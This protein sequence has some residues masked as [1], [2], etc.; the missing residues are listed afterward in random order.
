MPHLALSDAQ[1]PATVGEDHG[2]AP[3]TDGLGTA[4]VY[5]SLH[6]ATQP[7]ESKR[8]PLLPAI[9]DGGKIAAPVAGVFGFVGDVLSPLGPWVGVLLSLSIIG[10]CGLG[11]AVSQKIK[12]EKFLA[13]RLIPERLFV[14][15]LFLCLASGLWYCLT[16]L[17][18]DSDRGVVATI[19]PGIAAIQDSLLGLKDDVADVKADTTAILQDTGDI[20][21]ELGNIGRGGIIKNPTTP[22]EFYHNARFHELEGKFRDSFAAYA[23]YIDSNQEFVDPYITYLRLYQPQKG[24][25]AT[26]AEIARLRNR[27][28]QNRALHLVSLLLISGEEKRTELEQ[29]ARDNPEFGPAYLFAADSFV[30]SEL[31]SQSAVAAALENDYLRSF[32]AAADR[33][34]VQQ[35]YLDKLLAVAKVDEARARVNLNENDDKTFSLFAASPGTEQF[36]IND[37]N[38]KTVFYKFEDEDWTTLTDKAIQHLKSPIA[39]ITV[40][41]LPIDKLKQ[42]RADRLA[43]DPEAK[44]SLSLRYLDTSG[45]MSKVVTD[46]PFP[47]EEILGWQIRQEEKMAN[48]NKEIH[49]AL[50]GA[51]DD[52]DRINKNL[53]NMPG[54]PNIRLP[55]IQIPKF[56][57]P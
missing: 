54:G 7:A 47:V 17:A 5:H 51:D 9:I 31:P 24:A 12:A 29:F 14:F 23:K 13:N 38:V 36:S 40:V 22:A 3:L 6:I 20:K 26:Q 16:F 30:A 48:V 53:E 19:V 44:T 50:S 37:Y 52:F 41:R 46:G 42:Y 21:T 27:Y 35:Y 56:R 39:N 33:G 1:P 15:C 57:T 11:F 43:N 10:C 4:E 49:E 55:K 25:A 2:P 8:Q 32:I 45:R 34:H 28:P 18:S